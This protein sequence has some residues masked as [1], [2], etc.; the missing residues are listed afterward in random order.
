MIDSPLPIPDLTA[1][2]VDLVR[3]IPAGSVSTFGSLARALGDVT[4]ARWIAGWAKSASMENSLPWHRI[5]RANGDLWTEDLGLLQAALLTAEGIPLRDSQV[6][7]SNSAV[8]TPPPSDILGPLQQLQ[9]DWAS[10]RKIV[11]LSE[12]PRLV[13]GLDIS[14]HHD[15]AV[16]AYTLVDLE[17]AD[18]LWHVI[19]ESPVN[20]PYVS[21]YLAFRELPALLPVLQAA[22]DADQLA[23]VIMV[24]GNGQLH[25]RRAGIATLLGVLLDRPTI[26]VGKT[27]ICGRLTDPSTVQI[28]N[29]ETL[30]RSN[31]LDGD[32]PLGVALTAAGK[33]K[34]LY[35]SPGHLIDL[36]TAVNIA[37]RLLTTHRLPEPLHHADHLSRQA[38][39][40]RPKR[41]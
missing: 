13:G 16:A 18:L 2:L 25:P 34:P 14:Y 9:L 24:D 17:S 3:A 22:A 1:A 40:S 29:G 32:E 38:T 26:G 39:K 28:P 33:H 15:T 6:D 10:R 12:P 19:R 27:L 21:G 11:P 4:A 7:L 31:I 30:T 41:P 20:F 35:I 8:H 5:L 37:L 23:P 36:D